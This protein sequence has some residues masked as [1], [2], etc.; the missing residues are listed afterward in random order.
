MVVEAGDQPT[1]ALI[2]GQGRQREGRLVGLDSWRRVTFHFHPTAP[3]IGL[4]GDD[5]IWKSVCGD[6]K[7]S[8]MTRCRS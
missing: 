1:P 4:P 3:H 5:E 7:Q 8:S 2:G 6:S